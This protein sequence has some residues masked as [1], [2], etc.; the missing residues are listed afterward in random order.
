LA[1]TTR[2]RLVP[3]QKKLGESCYR[4]VD[5]AAP[6]VFIDV[7][8]IRGQNVATDLSSRDFTINAIAMRLD[9]CGDPAETIDPLNGLADL[10]GRLIRQ[11]GPEA[12]L[13]DPLRILRAFRLAAELDFRVDSGTL[14]SARQAAARLADTASERILVE[15]IRLFETAR[16]EPVLRLMDRCGALEAVIPEIKPMKGSSQNDFHHLDVWEHSLEVLRCCERILDEMDQNFAGVA[17]QVR[18]ILSSK[19][20]L[21]LLKLAALLHDVGKPSTRKQES[22]RVTFYGHDQEGAKLAVAIAERLRMSNQERDFLKAMVA[23]HLH[24]LNLSKPEVTPSARKR[25]FRNLGDDAIPLIILSMADMQATRGKLSTYSERSAHLEWS[26]KTVRNYF[27]KL[28]TELERKCL[29]SGLDLIEMGMQP[30]PEI[31]KILKK[32][33]EAQD[34]G[35]ISDREE[36]LEMVKIH[37]L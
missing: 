20:R 1:E 26:Q 15:I 25:L 19:R 32:V 13:R 17:D 7:C 18:G 31:G 33:Q 11:C 4:I 3:L 34:E 24:V 10:K 9:R 21:P 29:I 36:A 28:K 37:F 12:F 22:D 14:E 27:E 35:S 30:G 8:E 6:D 5:P 2:T 23:E 16:S